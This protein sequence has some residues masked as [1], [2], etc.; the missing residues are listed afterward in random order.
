MIFDF[1]YWKEL[2]AKD[3]EEFNRQRDHLIQQEAKRLIKDEDKQKRVI[4]QIHR[5][6]TEFDRIKNPIERFNRTQQSFWKQFSKFKDIVEGKYPEQATKHENNVIQFKKK[7][8]DKS[9]D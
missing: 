2:H 3:P 6:N 9:I 5:A 1:E 7:D 8:N 4:A